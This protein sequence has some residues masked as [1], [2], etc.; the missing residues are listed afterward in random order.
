VVIIKD[1]GGLRYGQ[2]ASAG[3]VLITTRTFSASRIKGQLRA[4]HGT[5]ETTRADGNVSFSKGPWG[6]T[7]KAGWDG[8]NGYK[9]NNKSEKSRAGFKAGRSFGEGKSLFL[10]MDGMSERKGMSGYPE[11]PTPHAKQKSY[12]VTMTLA[13]EWAGFQNNLY[14]N[15][16]SVKNVDETRSLDQ[17]L[18][19]AEYGD[20]LTYSGTLGPVSSTFGAGFQGTEAISSGF[21]NKS[22]SVVHVFASLGWRL[23]NLPFAIGAGARYDANS[24]FEN[25]LNPEFSLAFNKGRFEAA[26]K[27]S[28]AVNTPTFQQRFN[29]SSSTV[30]NPSLSIEK[31]TSQN[32][33]LAFEASSA[34]RLNAAVFH[35]VIRGRIS[36]VRPA[37]SPIGQYQNL[38]ESVYRGIDFGIS[39]KP[40]PKIEFK[41]RYTRLDAKD[42]EMNTYLTGQSRHYATIEIMARPM[43]RLSAAIKMEYRDRAFTDRL[44]TAVVKSRTLF[45]LRAEYEFGS[46]AFFLDG[47]NIF[48]A[49]YR[50][51]DGLQGPP[52]EIMAGVR[53]NF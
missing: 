51:A 3:V 31:V 8:T 49:D 53:W 24:D 36:H 46:Y 13:G 25:S 45:A 23:P 33:S 10:A 32:L 18:A 16:G 14:W 39:W 15:K 44:N 26:Y 50:H 40:S 17:S 43:E 2:D 22:E 12:N 29:H 30:P 19:V 27:Y 28:K 47:E 41:G 34:L 11:S 6:L 35:N 37:G 4:W 9:V 5:N 20:S 1:S 7:V 21:G 38:G 52:R 48:N 42:K